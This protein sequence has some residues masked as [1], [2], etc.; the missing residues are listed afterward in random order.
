MLLSAYASSCPTFFHAKRYSL[1]SKNE[2]YLD[3]FKKRV[4]KVFIPFVIWS[5]IYLAWKGEALGKP[6][7]PIELLLH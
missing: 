6:I 7:L 1:L 2:P 5:V 4:L 3:F